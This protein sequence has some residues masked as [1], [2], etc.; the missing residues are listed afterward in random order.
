MQRIANRVEQI[1]LL[2]KEKANAH[3]PFRLVSRL[4]HGWVRLTLLFGPT[5]RKYKMSVALLTYTPLPIASF[6]LKL[7]GLVC[8]FLILARIYWKKQCWFRCF[9]ECLRSLKWGGFSFNE[10]IDWAKEVSE[11][12]FKPLFTTKSK[13]QGFGLAVC[14]RLMEAQN[15]KSPSRAKKATAQLL[16]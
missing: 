7:N 15:S 14:K 5:T 12:I 8:L 10:N 9:C 1:R 3:L 6:F 2:N 11:K 16:L 4:A 13:G